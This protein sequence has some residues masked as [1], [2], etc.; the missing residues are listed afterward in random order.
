MFILQGSDHHWRR[1]E[2]ISGLLYI[3]EDTH[4]VYY[5]IQNNCCEMAAV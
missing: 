1:K 2:L 4:E 5:V 3:S